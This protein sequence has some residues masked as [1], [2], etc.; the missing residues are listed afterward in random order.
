M[1]DFA[2]K[3]KD[4]EVSLIRYMP[5]LASKVPEA[6][7]LGQG[8]PSFE[9]PEYIREK[10]IEALRSQKIINKYSL[11]PGM[12]ILKEEVAKYLER[13]KGV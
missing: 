5:V 11:E 1:K 12:P 3:V 7:S 10:L 4:I 2:K 6:V 9:L 8:I 13:T